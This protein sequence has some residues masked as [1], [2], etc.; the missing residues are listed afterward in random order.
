MTR[1]WEHGGR[2]LLPGLLGLLALLVP[3]VALAPTAAATGEDDLPLPAPGRPWFGPQLD[4]LTDSAVDYRE[5][6]GSDAA[7]YGQRVAYPLTQDSTF[8]LR[9]LVTESA[10]QGAVAVLS[11]EPSVPLTDLD[12]DDATALTDELSALHRELGSRYLLRFAPEMNGTWYSWGQQPSAYV[13]AFRALAD[14]VHD[15]VPSAAMVWSPVYGAGYPYGAAYG[16]VDPDR[17]ADVSALDTNGDRRLD[18]GDDPYGPFWPGADAVDWVGLTLY[19]FGPDRGRVDNELDDPGQGGQTGD[20]ESST[21]FRI[22]RVPGDGAFRSRLNEVY[23]YGAGAATR[24]FHDRF[25][26]GFDKPMLVDTGALWLPDPEGD[27][28]LDIK[29]AWWRQV[30]RADA[31]FPRIAGILWLEERRPEAEARDRT[32]DWRATR[33]P[34][35]AEALLRDL[36]GEVDLGPV[37][38]VVEPDPDDLD[39]G[40]APAGGEVEQTG[41]SPDPGL[42]TAVLP[43]PLPWWLAGSAIALL[44]LAGAAA[45]AARRR[46]EWRYTADGHDHAFA[47]H[48]DPRLDVVRGLLLVGLLAAHVEL[49]ATTDGPVARLMGGLVGPEAFVLV[50]GLAVGLRQE[51]LVEA[52]GALA[53]ASARWRRA[54]TWWALTVLVALVVLGLRYLPGDADHAVTRW[55]PGGAGRPGGADLYVDAAPLLEY[56]PPWWAVRE[57]FVLRTIPWPLSMLGLLVVLALVAPILVA[58]LRR[59]AWWLVLAGSWAA[60]AAGVLWTPDWTRGTWEAAYPPLLWQVVFVHGLVLAHHRREV[61]VLLARSGLRRAVV[62]LVLLVGLAWL[63]LTLAAAMAGGELAERLLDLTDGRD[64]PAGRLVALVLAALVTWLV[65]T[66]CWQPLRRVLEPVLAPLGAAATTVLVVHVLLLVALAALPL[67]LTTG[68]VRALATTGVVAV[69]A[70]APVVVRRRAPRA[71]PAT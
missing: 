59:R 37:T 20:V 41:P 39:V 61:R 21:G 68:W 60:Y 6:L 7:L 3:L 46:P 52:G 33:T 11:L 4:W 22:D 24:P 26:E 23:N 15:E 25:A 14:V 31:D 12:A 18:S 62:G 19:H 17:E 8:F 51:A 32:V 13:A 63:A 28:E 67:D 48:R 71:Q 45:L 49:L 57:L 53:A 44:V 35:L 66:A 5:R 50:A 54:L 27:P 38:P 36:V 69:V 56:P 2:R 55:L 58:L 43:V 30:L 65:L 64:L 40:A 47:G 16:D 1:V 42:A 9:R 70:L 10:A 29:R 34:Q